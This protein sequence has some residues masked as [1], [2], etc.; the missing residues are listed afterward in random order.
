[1]K[2]DLFAKMLFN[3]LSNNA[4]ESVPVSYKQ[5]LKKILPLTLSKGQKDDRGERRKRISFCEKIAFKFLDLD[6][7]GQIGL[8]DLFY[9]C[10]NFSP[11]QSAGV[12]LQRM[13]EEKL[14]KKAATFI[15]EGKNNKEKEIDTDSWWNTHSSVGTLVH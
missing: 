7:D 15:N 12:R 1:M 13:K 8:N 5:F 3:W 10:S 4:H 6:G 2:N 11:K 9:L 14:L